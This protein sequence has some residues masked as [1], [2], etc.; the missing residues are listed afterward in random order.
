MVW[1]R[2]ESIVN[3]FQI[4][5]VR[6][7][8]KLKG[9]KEGKLVGFY[10]QRERKARITKFKRKIGKWLIT[11]T[12]RR[13]LI[14]RSEVARLKTRY[15]GKFWSSNANN[16]EASKVNPGSRI[17]SDEEIIRRNQELSMY[18]AQGDLNM[19]VHL[20]IDSFQITQ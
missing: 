3:K 14:G 13:N 10:T 18:E 1:R 20:A 8:P 5:R 19:I 16:S 11:H 9:I 15:D 12:K 6:N 4:K 7:T 17:L 2:R